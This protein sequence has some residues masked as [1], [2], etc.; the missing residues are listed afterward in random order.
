MRKSFTNKSLTNLYMYVW[1]SGIY[2]WMW[3]AW[4]VI[5]SWQHVLQ[6]TY[7]LHCPNIST[8]IFNKCT[9]CMTRRRQLICIWMCVFA[10]ADGE[11]AG[12]SR[13]EQ[14]QSSIRLTGI[15]SKVSSSEE[16]AQ[17][18]WRGAAGAEERVS[19][20]VRLRQ[21]KDK[22]QWH[23]LIWPGYRNRIPQLPRHYSK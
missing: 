23:A 18:S 11:R 15:E 20:W 13:G 8:Y 9:E 1:I 12:D 22:Q 6:L 14:P 17:F 2:H 21:L 10:Q 16:H 4:K 3:L 7:G 5:K 19:E